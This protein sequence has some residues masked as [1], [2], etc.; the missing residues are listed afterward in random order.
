MAEIVLGMASSH[1]PM[2]LADDD[3]LPLF[4]EWDA[5]VAKFDKEGNPATFNDLLGKAAPGMADLVTQDEL[6]RKLSQAREGMAR[7][8][9]TLAEA[10]LDA[11]IVIGD[12]QDESYKDDNRPAIAVYWGDTINNRYNPDEGLPEWFDNI[13]SRY[14]DIEEPR[15]FPVDSKLGLH[16]IDKLMEADF[17]IGSSARLPEGEGEGHAVAFV[18]KWLM[19]ANKPI[20]VVPVLL[21]TYY[22]PNQPR[23]ARCFALGQAIRRAVES[24]GPGRVGVL[25]SGGLSHFLV[26]ESFDREIIEALRNKDDAFMSNISMNKLKQGSSEILNW[27]CLAGAVGDIPLRWVDYI[28]GYRTPAGTGTGIS[29]A[30]WVR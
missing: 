27:I 1:T 28:P 10:Q 23:P 18:H 3:V 17:D 5:K 4:G 12:D 30:E 9:K 7:L 16:L 8:R 25:A 19:D 11:L 24:Y 29:F 14:F 2:L 22:P 13:R 21:N 20:P 15:D 6:L 26:D